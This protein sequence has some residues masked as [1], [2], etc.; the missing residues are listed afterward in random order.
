MANWLT[1]NMWLF[2]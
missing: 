1:R 2:D